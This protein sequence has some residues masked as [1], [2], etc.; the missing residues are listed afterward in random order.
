MIAI[1]DVCS[2]STSNNNITYSM[3][4]YIFYGIFLVCSVSFFADYNVKCIR[5]LL[6]AVHWTDKLCSLTAEAI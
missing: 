2:S 1:R 5:S 6:F 3:V 4:Y